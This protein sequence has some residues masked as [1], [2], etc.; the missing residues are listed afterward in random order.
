MDFLI[1]VEEDVKVLVDAQVIHNQ[2]GSHG[3]LASMWNKMAV[4]LPIRLTSHD[5]EVIENVNK[6][7]QANWSRWRAAFLDTYWDK[8]PWLLISIVAAL[9][10]FVLTALQT[11]YTMTQY[12][13]P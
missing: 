8:K 1:D 11:I 13:H 10:L 3:E 6:A 9:F 5:A 2:L 7:C 12:Y 4:N